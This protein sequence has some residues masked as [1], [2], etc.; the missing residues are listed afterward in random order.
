ML[1]AGADAPR[2]QPASTGFLAVPVEGILI[3]LLLPA[4]Q[5]AREAARLQLIDSQGNLILS[6]PLGGGPSFFDIFY[7]DGSVTPAE[8]RRT[9]M[10]KERS[11]PRVWEVPTADGILIGLLLPAVQKNGSSAG[12]LAGSVQVGGPNGTISAILPFIEPTA[13]HVRLPPPTS[14]FVGPFTLTNGEPAQVGLLLPAVQKVREAAAR[15]VILNS[16]GRLVA[17]DEIIVPP[18]GRAGHFTTFY[19]LFLGDGSVRVE[20]RSADGS[21]RVGQGVSPD[22]ILIGLLLPAVKSGDG[23][24]RMLGGSLLTPSTSVAFQGANA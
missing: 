16:A 12:L 15:L 19:D 6:I 23:S 9:L 20:R 22:G 4:V 11:G 14:A 21:V 8:N 13:L 7:G 1:P 24:V 10:V 2:P 3:G 17:Q 5:A 18:E